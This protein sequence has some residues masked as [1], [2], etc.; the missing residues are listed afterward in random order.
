[1]MIDGIPLLCGVV[2]TVGSTFEEAEYPN[3]TC[4]GSPQVGSFVNFGTCVNETQFYFDFS[5][6]TSSSPSALPSSMV[7]FDDVSADRGARQVSVIH[8][9]SLHRGGAGE[10]L[11][12][13]RSLDHS[14]VSSNRVAGLRKKLL[15]RF[16]KLPIVTPPHQRPPRSSALTG[17]L[18]VSEYPESACGGNAEI[19]VA[20]P[21]G[22]CSN[23][24]GQTSKFW[25]FNGEVVDGP[26]TY[27][28]F[29]FEQYEEQDCAGAGTVE[30][31]VVPQL[32]CED[33][34][35]YSY[36]TTLLFPSGGFY[37]G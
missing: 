13:K 6:T 7:G 22:V 29:T 3:P 14:A 1:M 36:E 31:A 4:G 33:G 8:R 35:K 15:G 2:V 21:I 18:Y 17:Y 34:V 23:T 32:T 5:C 9:S 27:L 26:T 19:S 30:L 16:P 10:A 25:K 11:A 37:T 12:G 28:N 24:E 20:Y